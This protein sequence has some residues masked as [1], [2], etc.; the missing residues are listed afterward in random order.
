MF[1]HTIIASTLL[2]AALAAPTAPVV[3]YHAPVVV[4]A[5]KP[6]AFQ[7]GVSDSYSGSNFA[8]SET[9]DTKA[10]SG[11]YSVD[12]PDGRKQTVT[13]HADPLADGGFVADVTYEGTASYPDTPVHKPVVVKPIVHPAP[14]H[15][16]AHPVAH[17][18]AHP[19]A[20]TLAHPVA[21]TLS[22]PVAH[23]LAHP[24]THTLAHPVV[25]SVAHPTVHTVAHPVVQSL[26]HPTNTV[27]H[28]VAHPF[29]LHG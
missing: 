6:Y 25:H 18:V 7:Y 12:L 9:S 11:S 2:A 26:I 13:Y 19:V 29:V 8:Q 28:H 15:V 23:T 17:A 1:P 21:H 3:P 5:P 24:V 20:H 14:V 22:H 10:V 4:E 27:A 16:V